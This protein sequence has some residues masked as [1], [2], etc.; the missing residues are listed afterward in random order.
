MP[1]YQNQYRQPSGQSRSGIPV[2]LVLALGMALFFLVSYYLHKQVNPVTGRAQHIAVSME[3]EVAM[4]LQAA[5][6]M[7]QQFGG[8]HPD[9]KAR[10][11][12]KAVGEQLVANLP[13]EAPEYPFDFHL[14]ADP[15][16]VNAFA[17]PGGQIFITS[18]LLERL[19]TRGQ[20]AGVLGHEIGHVLGRHSAEQMAKAQLTQGLVGAATVGASDYANPRSTQQI[21][22]MVGNMVMLKYGRGDEL[23]SDKLG[24]QF[25]HAAGYDPRSLIRVMEILREASGGSRQPEFMSSHPD[26]GNRIEHIQQEIQRLFPGGVPEGLTK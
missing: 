17:L 21:A 25:M 19:E 22:G 6:E 10:E 24:L 16:T 1:L 13:P 23:E 20:L 9:S 14:L 26:P 3:Q 11:L 18:A 4:G 7:A 12:V 5:P 2:K 15:K 8:L